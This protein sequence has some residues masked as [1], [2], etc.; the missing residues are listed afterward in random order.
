MPYTKHLGTIETESDIEDLKRLRYN[1]LYEDKNGHLVFIAESEYTYNMAVEKNPKARF[2]SPLSTTISR[3]TFKNK[4]V[5]KNSTPH[6]Q[7]Y[8]TFT[9]SNKPSP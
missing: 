6:S 9:P 5:L 4:W 2:L 1:S 7:K 8:Q 3:L